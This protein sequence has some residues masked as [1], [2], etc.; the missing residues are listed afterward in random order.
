MTKTIVLIF[1]KLSYLG[2][3]LITLMLLEFVDSLDKER[4]IKNHVANLYY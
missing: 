2:K 4:V 3:S 1:L